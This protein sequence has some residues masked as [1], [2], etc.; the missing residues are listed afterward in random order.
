MRLFRFAA[1]P[2]QTLG[3]SHASRRGTYTLARAMSPNCA[4]S[5]LWQRRYW[6]HAIRDGKDLARHLDY[7]HF[8]PVKHG[9]VT[10]VVTGRTVAFTAT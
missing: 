3:S 8:N 1:M 2:D 10:R 5:G 6:E 4:K 7:I 9:L